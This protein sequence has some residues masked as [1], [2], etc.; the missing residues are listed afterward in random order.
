VINTDGRGAEYG[1]T[2]NGEMFF[3]PGP[4]T[5]GSLQRRMFTGPWQLNFD[6]SV[7]KQFRLF[8]GHTLDLHFDFFNF[9]NH[10]TFA[11]APSTAGDYGSVTNVNI[12]NTTFGK[13]T[14]Q[15]N[16]PRIVQIGAYYRF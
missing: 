12:N 7:K 1:S 16:T 4:G 14:I 8:E 3:N 15:N 9:M 11:P 10:P 2:F 6:G 5:V 13:I